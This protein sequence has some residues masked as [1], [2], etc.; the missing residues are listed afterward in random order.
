MAPTDAETSVAARRLEVFLDRLGAGAA[1]PVG[2]LLDPAYTGMLTD[3]EQELAGRLREV[4]A[5]LEG[6]D[7]AETPAG[8]EVMQVLQSLGLGR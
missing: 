2:Y 6:S 1:A 4:A 7:P 3:A 5:P 8:R